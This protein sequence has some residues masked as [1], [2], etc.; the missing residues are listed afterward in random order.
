[1][2]HGAVASTE[3]VGSAVRN[4]RLAVQAEH[5]GCGFPD[6]QD[7]PQ[8]MVGSGGNDGSATGA[9]AVVVGTI[10]EGAVVVA[11]VDVVVTDE[12]VAA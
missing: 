11:G 6:G 1:M 10:V 7:S 2:P 4:Q 12:V 8:G 3:R 9:G 5:G